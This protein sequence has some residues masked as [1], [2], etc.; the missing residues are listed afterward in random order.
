MSQLRISKRDNKAKHSY[1]KVADKKTWNKIIVHLSILDAYQTSLVQK[2][3]ISR[4][5]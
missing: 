3:P 1:I 5:P 4:R 2:S